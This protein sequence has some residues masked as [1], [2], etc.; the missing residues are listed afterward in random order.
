MEIKNKQIK[1]FGNGFYINIPSQ[2]LK[3]GV[4]DLDKKYNLTLNEKKEGSNGN[5]DY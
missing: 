5:K 2:Y 3:D 4:F 1:K